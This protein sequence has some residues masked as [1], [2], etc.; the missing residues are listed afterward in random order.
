MT[1]RTALDRTRHRLASLVWLGA[2]ACALFLAVGALVV[3][4][5][6]DRSNDLVALVE[7]TAGTL[8]LGVLEQF[9]G[10]D[11]RTR[12]ALVSWGV[13]AIGY[14]VVG[15]ILDRLIRP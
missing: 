6:L 11:A 13:P 1:L 10:Q 4:L 5:E 7:R 15:W 9:A 12:A 2:V 3:A 14:L 8:D